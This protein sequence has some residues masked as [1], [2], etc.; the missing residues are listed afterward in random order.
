MYEILRVMLCVM[1]VFGGY[2]ALRIAAGALI[3][4]AERRFEVSGD[5]A[6][7]ESGEVKCPEKGTAGAKESKRD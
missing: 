6:E 5:G 3:R 7:S 1:A 4:R 2:I